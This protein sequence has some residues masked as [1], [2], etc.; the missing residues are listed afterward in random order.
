MVRHGCAISWWKRSCDN[1]GTEGPE[2]RT[3]MLVASGQTIV[4]LG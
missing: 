2:S 3:T 4:F 1:D